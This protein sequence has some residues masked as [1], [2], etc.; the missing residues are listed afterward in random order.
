MGTEAE[1]FHD[2]GKYEFDAS[3][4]F[5]LLLVLHLHLLKRDM[6]FVCSHLGIKGGVFLPATNIFDQ[7]GL[8]PSHPCRKIAFVVERG[9]V[10]FHVRWGEDSPNTCDWCDRQGMRHGMTPRKIIQLPTDF[11]LLK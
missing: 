9:V 2:L 1:G 6:F 11:H 10:H 8:A 4:G 7:H 3:L 5:Q